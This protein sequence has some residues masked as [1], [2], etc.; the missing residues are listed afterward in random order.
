MVGQ[1]RE[2]YAQDFLQGGCIVW[3]YM[4]I[5]IF[6][7]RTEPARVRV[8]VVGTLFHNLAFCKHYTTPFFD[9]SKCCENALKAAAFGGDRFPDAA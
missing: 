8:V 5:H 3:I 7:K 2:F 9:D 1:A 4:Y 6:T